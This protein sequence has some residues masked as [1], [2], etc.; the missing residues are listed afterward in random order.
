MS[1]SARQDVRIIPV[2]DIRKGLIVH[3]KEGR[4]GDYLPIVSQL[5]RNTDPL[6]IAAA[7]RDQFGFEEL[8]L[9][10]LDALE[11][12]EPLWT[13]YTAL[14][15]MGFRLIV[16]AGV[17]TVNRALRIKAAGA[18]KVVVALETS[19]NPN[20]LAHVIGHLR[21]M[22]VVFSLDLLNGAPLG[23]IHN[24]AESDP[25]KI[26]GTAVDFG[27]EHLIV[28]D[29]AAVGA[30]RGCLTEQICADIHSQWP[31]LEIVTGGGIGSMAEARRL[32]Q[33]GVQGTLVASALHD[34]RIRPQDLRCG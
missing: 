11:G 3:G 14:N 25:M 1:T 17:R 8:Y 32:G 13:T 20:L 2:L 24:A 12:A 22:N 26:V 4:R 31:D 33:L 19:P 27:Y 7:F 21:P 10:D 29:L 34:G 9:A 16:D 30:N 15:R 6:S 5:T 23:S 28:L 18:D